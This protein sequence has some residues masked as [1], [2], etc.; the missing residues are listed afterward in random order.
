MQTDFPMKTLWM[1]RDIETM[2]RE[3]LIDVVKRLGRDLEN[4]RN[5]AASTIRTMAS[6]ARAAL[7]A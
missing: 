3:E 5:L 7:D 4:T 1:G 6:M 2:S